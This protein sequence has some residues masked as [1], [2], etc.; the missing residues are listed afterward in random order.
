MKDNPRFLIL[1]VGSTSTKAAY[2][3]GRGI[4]AEKNIPLD[5][6]SLAAC[7]TPADQLPLRRQGLMR[8]LEENGI[9]LAGIDLFISRGGLGKPGPAGAYRIDERMTVDLMNGKYGMHPS[10]IGPAL[11][12]ALGGEFGKNALVVDPPS[13]DEFEPLARISGIPEIERKS[14][15]HALNQKA[16]ARKVSKQ[17]GKRY[18]EMNFVVAHL[19]GGI[20]VGAHG[21]GKVV[22]CTHGLAEGP[23]TPE[24]A[25]GLPATD[26]VDLAGKTDRGDL[27]RRL[28]GEGGLAAY[29]G[30]KDAREVES[31]IAGG[32]EKARIIYEAMAYQTA[33]DIGAMATVLRG[34]VDGI[35]LTGGLAHSEML[36]RWI[37]DRVSF[38][39][40]VYLSPGED[41]MKALAEGGMRIWKGEE[42]LL[43]YNRT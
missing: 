43:D 21:K 42:P 19:G 31:R 27:L 24:R 6:A 10:A 23:F 3:D 32:D 41:E 17:L 1:N 39:A 7:R 18:E 40:P 2:F 37:R 8:F 15:F 28:V 35:I 29:L 38:L 14:A 34:K 5:G 20:T 30:T 4:A 12:L 9:D 36:T 13:T 16:A 26:L 11:A 25:G 33:K 22:D